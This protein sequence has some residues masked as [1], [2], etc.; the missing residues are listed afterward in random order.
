MSRTIF[1][2]VIPRSGRNTVE[3]IDANRY[4][5]RSTVVPERGKANDAVVKLLAKH[6]NVAP[7]LLELVSGGKSREKTFVVR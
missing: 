5:V 7:S 3:A 6:L 2:K 4:V 1:V